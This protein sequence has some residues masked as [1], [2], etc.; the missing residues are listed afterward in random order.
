MD[1]GCYVDT[2]VIIARYKPNDE[3]YEHS[4]RLFSRDDVKFYASPLTLVELY[5]VLSRLLDELLIPQGFEKDLDALV[6]FIVKDCKLNVV[7]HLY[8][9]T[10]DFHARK[11]RMPLEYYLTFRY[12]GRLKLRALDLIHICYAKILNEFYDVEFF[13]T[14][15]EELLS[16]AE[17]A[18]ELLKLR[19]SHPRDIFIA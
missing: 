4:E 16:K 17:V 2:S 10:L 15:D 6:G 19:I 11:I 12:A 13:V 9:L 1:S 3:L 7:P 8:T 18:S 5:A 14:G